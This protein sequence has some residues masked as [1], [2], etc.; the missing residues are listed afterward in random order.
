MPRCIMGSSQDG[1]ALAKVLKKYLSGE[2]VDIFRLYH[3]NTCSKVATA[4][5]GSVARLHDKRQRQL[6]PDS[7]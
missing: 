5:H 2:I 3:G 6:E 4:T 1:C 7:A